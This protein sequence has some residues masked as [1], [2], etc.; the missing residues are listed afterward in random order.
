MKETFREG[1]TED[2]AKGR[3]DKAKQISLAQTRVWASIPE[4][5]GRQQRFLR[6][7][8]RQA[9]NCG[10]SMINLQQCRECTF[11]VPFYFYMVR[12]SLICLTSP[13]DSQEEY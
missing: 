8:E 7:S 13:R 3:R 9:Q 2:R 11:Y 10:L 4:S 1:G 6:N 12:F 5:L